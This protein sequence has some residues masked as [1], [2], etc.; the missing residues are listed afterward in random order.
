LF[1]AFC[2]FTRYGESAAS[3]KE[4]DAQEH[5][6]LIRDPEEAH[7]TGTPVSVGGVACAEHGRTE[8]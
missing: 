2:R 1:E 7:H 4:F 5:H 8:E 6:V 3:A